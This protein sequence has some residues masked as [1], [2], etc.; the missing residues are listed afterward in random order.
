MTPADR[1][2]EDRLEGEFVET[3]VTDGVGTIRIDRAERHNSLVPTLCEELA[4][5]VDQLAE[6]DR[7]RVLHLETAGPSFSTGG[8]VGELYAHRDELAAY[9]DRLVGRLNGAL[10]AFARAPQPTVVGVDGQVT[11]GALGL[12]LVAD[13]VVMGPDATIIP[14]YPVVGFSPDGG[15]TALLPAIIG[16][17]RTTSLLATNG[18]MTAEQALEWG[19]AAELVNDREAVEERTASIAREMAGMATGSLEHTKRLVGP[20]VDELEERLATERRAFLEQVETDEALEGMAAF[21]ER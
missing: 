12:L 13:V 5:A 15:W 16:S 7:V 2:D 14:Y 3:T 11:G 4:N 19:L 6:D 21:L 17:K 1:T 20:D 8:D 10:L 18:S 9:A